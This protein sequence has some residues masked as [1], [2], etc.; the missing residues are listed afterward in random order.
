MSYRIEPKPLCCFDYEPI[1]WRRRIP[2]KLPMARQRPRSCSRSLIVRTGKV[3]LCAL[4]FVHWS[5]SEIYQNSVL[6]LSYQ[7]PLRGYSAAPS[8]RRHSAICARAFRRRDAPNR[9]LCRFR[10]SA[11][12]CRRDPSGR[13]LAQGPNRRATGSRGRSRSGSNEA[14]RATA[15]SR[16]DRMATGASNRRWLERLDIDRA[17]LAFL[18]IHLAFEG[19]LLALVE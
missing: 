13:R 16:C 12:R 19:H 8:D 3:H 11:A 14:F 6:L 1:P 10:R 9:A 2:T 17:S 5:L 15:P 7:F 4:M 18:G